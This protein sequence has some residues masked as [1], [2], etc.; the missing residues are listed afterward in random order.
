[1]THL[2]EAPALCSQSIHQNLFPW[3]VSLDSYF[4]AEFGRK[5]S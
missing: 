4:P 3:A 5:K 1:V 2:E